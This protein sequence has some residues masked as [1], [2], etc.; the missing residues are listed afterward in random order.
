[1]PGNPEFKLDN[2]MEMRR[3]HMACEI[4]A[5]MPVLLVSEAIH[6]EGMLTMSISDRYGFDMSFAQE[7]ANEVVLYVEQLQTKFKGQ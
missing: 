3:Q 5:R 7:V 4:A 6:S 2:A 1:M